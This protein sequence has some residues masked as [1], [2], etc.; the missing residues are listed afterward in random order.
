MAENQKYNVLGNVVMESKMSLTVSN[1]SLGQE[2]PLDESMATY[3]SI[4]AW[5]IPWRVEP[6]GLQSIGLQKVGHN[7]VTEHTQTENSAQIAQV[8]KNARDR[9]GSLCSSSLVC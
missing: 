1:R 7:W 9:W 5:E 3:S 8:N 6:G 2:D 4:L